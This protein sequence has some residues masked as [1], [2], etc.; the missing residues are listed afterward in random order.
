MV[1]SNT[2]TT[3][4]GQVHNIIKGTNE[5]TVTETGEVSTTSTN[6]ACNGETKRVNGRLVSQVMEAASYTITIKET[7]LVIESE[8]ITDPIR[9]TTL[10]GAKWEDNGFQTPLV[11][12]IWTHTR[13]E[14]NLQVVNRI[15][16]EV[17]KFNDENFLVEKNKQYF[18]K[19]IP[20]PIN[21]CGIPLTPTDYKDIYVAETSTIDNKPLKRVDQFNL[22][23]FTYIDMKQDFLFYIIKQLV[24]TNQ[25]DKDNTLTESAMAHAANLEQH[26][27]YQFDTDSFFISS[28]DIIYTFK[29]QEVEVA[30]LD[31]T[32]DKCTTEL[33]VLHD[34]EER[35]IQ[36]ITHILSNIPS[37]IPCSKHFAPAYKSTNGQWYIQSPKLTKI[38][39]PKTHPKENNTQ[40]KFRS[41]QGEQ[42]P[43]DVVD[44]FNHVIQ[45]GWTR[46]DVMNRVVF[47]TCSFLN[48]KG[49]KYQPTDMTTTYHQIYQQAIDKLSQYSSPTEFFTYFYSK[50]SSCITPIMQA[51]F[52]IFLAKKV[53]DILTSFCKLRSHGL[54]ISE[55]IKKAVFSTPHLLNVAHTPV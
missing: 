31:S 47:L 2:F 41:S 13:Q 46:T 38:N 36:P 27:I 44:E 23:L 33:A 20:G 17:M 25:G 43:P 18:I 34:G 30:A 7:P 15:N 39:M 28:G 54:D 16:A 37:T 1:D 40:V 42:Y 24:E 4:D 55:C 52:T 3:G 50:Y 21:L 29:C 51:C 53:I 22:N 8:T 48:D 26:K 49:C 32:L 5:I 12:Y 45:F 11:T 6:V 14:C 19:L 35:F 10:H 9:H